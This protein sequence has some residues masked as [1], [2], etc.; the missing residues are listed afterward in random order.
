M[1]TGVEGT[2]VLTV[3]PTVVRTGGEWGSCRARTDSITWDLDTTAPVF[4]SPLPDIVTE[5]LSTSDGTVVTFGAP[6]FRDNPRDRLDH[7]E[8]PRQRLGLPGRG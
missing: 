7:Q 5:V 2:Y 6:T 8:H 3:V 1:R 4:T